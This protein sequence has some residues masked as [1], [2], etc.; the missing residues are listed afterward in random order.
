MKVRKREVQIRRKGIPAKVLSVQRSCSEGEA[1][2]MQKLSMPRTQ[3][4]RGLLGR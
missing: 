1:L 2:E 4:V 3:R